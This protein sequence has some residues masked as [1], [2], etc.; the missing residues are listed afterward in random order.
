MDEA[1][2]GSSQDVK[3]LF[4]RNHWPV[5]G[6]SA[7]VSS[8]R[9]RSCLNESGHSHSLIWRIVPFLLSAWAFL[10]S[11][12]ATARKLWAALKLDAAASLSTRSA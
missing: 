3:C 2:S 8:Q 6:Q 10:N 12:R 1:L 9:C 5:F 7:R 11:L 4:R